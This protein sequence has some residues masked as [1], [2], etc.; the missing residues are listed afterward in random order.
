MTAT[1][2]PDPVAD[3]GA[4]TRALMELLGDRDPLAVQREL[5]PALRAAIAGLADA[6]LRRPERPGKWSIAQVIQH[7]ADSEMTSAIRL[8]R[9]LA[10]D[11]A[12]IV[13]YD[14]DAFARALHYDRPIA[15][16]LEAFK[17]ARVSTAEILDRLSEADWA[18]AGTHTESGPYSVTRWLEIYAEH[19]EKHAGRARNT[20]ENPPADREDDG[21]G[22]QRHEIRDV[23]HA[24]HARRRAR[25]AGRPVVHAQDRTRAAIGPRTTLRTNIFP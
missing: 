10:E 6:D 3:P 15:A 21:H 18:R 7:L 2:L 8:R 22:E 11:D 23:T 1:P 25:I 13:G 4:Y 16:S 24:G 5:V 19:A 20:S 17:W 9:L 14:Q 12:V